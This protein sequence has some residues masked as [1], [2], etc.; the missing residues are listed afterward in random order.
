VTLIFGP[1][2]QAGDEGEQLSVYHSQQSCASG[3]G[4][5]LR[6]ACNAGIVV[7]GLVG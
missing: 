5:V 6:A 7:C 1:P 4:P 3:E 2:K